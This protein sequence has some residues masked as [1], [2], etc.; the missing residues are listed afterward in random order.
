MQWLER[1]T[2]VFN[3]IEQ[4][5]KTSGLWAQ[6]TPKTEDLE[7]DM[8]FCVD[9]LSFEQWL[10]FVFLPKMRAIVGNGQMPPGPAQLY[11]IGEEAFKQ[12][13][14]A[15]QLLEL[16]KNFDEVSYLSHVH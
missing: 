8:P 10:Q 2:M 11:P 9:T 12:R 7:S 13:S 6:N 1:Y 15:K 3:S 16:L 14:E 4:E 5:M